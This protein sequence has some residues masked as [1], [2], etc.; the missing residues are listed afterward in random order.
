MSEREYMQ[1]LRFCTENRLIC[2]E[3]HRRHPEELRRQRPPL[4][5]TQK[6]RKEARA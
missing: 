3:Y 6:S 4:P 5:R 2:F 1:L